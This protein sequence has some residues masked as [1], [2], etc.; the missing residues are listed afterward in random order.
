M[1]DQ[2]LLWTGLIAPWLTLFFMPKEAIKRYMSVTVFVSLLVTILCE[3][4]Y[5][6]KWWEITEYITPWGYITNASFVYGTFFVGTI[7]IFHL[8]YRSFWLYLATN[9]AIDAL[10]AFGLSPFIEGRFF[11]YISFNSFLSFLVMAVLA[12]LIFGY[13]KWQEGIFKEQV[14][15]FKSHDLTIKVTKP[16]S[17]KIKIR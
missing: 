3:A 9:L 8:T 14:H 5:H 6:Y 7:W 12:V 17:R 13:Q 11:R 16:F 4:A 2:L 10:F 1:F 15:P